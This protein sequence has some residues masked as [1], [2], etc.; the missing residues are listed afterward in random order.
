MADP[1]DNITANTPVAPPV[2]PAGP[3]PAV[4]PPSQDDI[5]NA[6]DFLNNKIDPTLG[7]TVVANYQNGFTGPIALG[8]NILEREGLITG[9]DNEF[10]KG[11]ELNNSIT[12]NST[13]VLNNVAGFA[14]NLAGSLSNPL[15]WMVGGPTFKIASKAAGAGFAA[16]DVGTS[17]LATRALITGTAGGTAVGAV[18]VAPYAF[19]DNYKAASNTLDTT[20]MVKELGVGA[21]LGFALGTIPFA[22][23]L[24]KEIGVDKPVNTAAEADEAIKTYNTNPSVIPGGDGSVSV[25]M[26]SE[27]SVNNFTSILSDMMSADGE[28][29]PDVLRASLGPDFAK[30]YNDPQMQGVLDNTISQ[31]E[32]T[33][34]NFFNEMNFND[35]DHP[36][37]VNAVNNNVELPE[38]APDVINSA[39]EPYS[40]SA[41][42]L[43][44][45]DTTQMVDPEKSAVEKLQ[46]IAALKQRAADYSSRL[47]FLKNMQSLFNDD[48][49]DA[50]MGGKLNDYIARA[51][52]GGEKEPIQ[53]EPTEKSGD[54]GKFAD[55]DPENIDP[56]AMGIKQDYEDNEAAAE[57]LKS[58]NKVF[59]ALMSCIR[60]KE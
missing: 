39:T 32:Q 25:E 20:G 33:H 30:I 5:N 51:A 23:A 44:S 47:G 13:G 4:A 45:I 43:L 52:T 14:A 29:D 48:Y 18:G 58:K 1:L 2:A 3:A 11:Y 41:S 46:G 49:N 60:G 16:F 42:K 27:N 34:T 6:F 36:N 15:T 24:L 7:Q 17:N 22:R 50:E 19:D 59:Q 54:S 37:M 10:Q 55:L 9:E 40:D 12:A 31:L 28:F 53:A 38:D 56:D 35:S 21:G 26:A 8:S 57:S